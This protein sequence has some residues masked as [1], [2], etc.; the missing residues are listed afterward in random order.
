MTRATPMTFGP[1]VED[2]VDVVADGSPTSVRSECTSRA[3]GGQSAPVVAP[4]RSALSPDVATGTWVRTT[5]PSW[6]GTCRTFT[7]ELDDGSVHTA[8]VD[9]RRRAPS[10]PRHRVGRAGCGACPGLR[11]CWRLSPCSGM[12]SGRPS[13]S[14][15][16]GRR[17]SR[18]GPV[19]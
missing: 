12:D 15:P 18:L 6:A 5:E 13:T 9:V 4:S 7:L 19:G 14:N 16:Q 8:R 2:G 3:L 11:S 1:V 17:S 10:G